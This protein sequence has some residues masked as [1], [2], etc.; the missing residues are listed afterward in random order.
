MAID[1]MKVFKGINFAGQASA[2]SSPANGDVYYDTTLQKLRCYQNGAWVNLSDSDGTVLLDDGT[3]SAPS[4]SFLNET[5]LGLYRQGAGVLAIA[6]GGADLITFDAAKIQT[7]TPMHIDKNIYIGLADQFPVG[8]DGHT[9]I[10]RT[11]GTGS[12]PFNEAGTAIYRSRVSSTAGRSS[13]LFYTGSP[14]TLAMS[15]DENQ[16][17]TLGASGGTQTHQINGALDI[18]GD[19]SASSRFGTFGGEASVQGSAYSFS[20][21]KTAP[22]GTLEGR[23]LGVRA[24]VSGNSPQTAVMAG[25]YYESRRTGI[26]ASVTDTGEFFSHTARKAIVNFTATGLGAA[27][28]NTS[29]WHGLV[30]EGGGSLNLTGN[31]IAISNYNGIFFRSD[32][33]ANTG[34]KINIRLNTL[35]G[36]TN[37]AQIADNNTFTGDWFIN[38][39]STN[40]SL[41]SGHLNLAGQKELRL[42]DTTGGEYVGH[43]AP[44]TVTSSHTYTWPAAL[45]AGNRV[46]QSDSSGNLS[47]VTTTPGSGDIS[48]GGNTFGAAIT[49]GTNDAFALNF[50]T[51]NVIKGSITSAG[52]WTLGES[53]GTQTH[54]VNGNLNITQL[55]GVVGTP[56][57]SLMQVGAS[58]NQTLLSGT[59]Q[60]GLRASIRSNSSATARTL[61]L[62]AFYQ[63]EATAY[64]TGVGAG[65]RI[66][67]PTIGATSIVTRNIGLLFQ[68]VGTGGTNNA[69]IS[70]NEAFTGNWFIN[71]TSTNSSRFSGQIGIGQNPLADRLLFVG[72]SSA[73]LFTGTTQRIIEVGGANFNSNATNSCSSFASNCSALP[74][75][76]V[77]NHFHHIQ[78]SVSGTV[79][80]ERAFAISEKATGAGSVTN[81][82]GI[83]DNTTFTGDWFINSTSTNPSQLSG[84]VTLGASAGTAV[85]QLNGGVRH[86]VRSITGATTLDTTTTDYIVLANSTSAAFTVTLPA[87]TSGRKII[88]KDSGGSAQTNNITVSPASGTIDGAASFVINNNYQSID[89]VSDGTN[90]WIC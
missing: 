55:V 68:D 33:L 65:I 8:V 32:T 85:H 66:Q 57:V 1:F 27:Y 54:A 88:I 59:T 35:S 23:L 81:F 53:A 64:T 6:Q 9:L 18:S 86:T 11:D 24:N 79:T 10:L 13:H 51:N 62:A 48:N 25:G 84:S 4:L 17:I 36:G 3:V 41:L 72:T 71:S 77:M 82:A 75:T 47:W 38:S 44:G 45:P 34:R 12:A 70:D 52:A 76:G 40:D 2:P 39:T 74:T 61:G 43:R 42:Q 73:T 37:N 83:A 21:V 87:A 30:I 14:T 90:W 7:E 63:T 78:A 28:A 5:G 49:I 50:E 58:A 67:T 22:T 56:T 29:G 19:A 20:F 46:L 80:R 15:I 26:S 89:L 69:F 16:K 31:S 60:E